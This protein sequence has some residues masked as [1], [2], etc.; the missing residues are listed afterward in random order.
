MQTWWNHHDNFIRHIMLASFLPQ[1]L[2][3]YSACA[4]ELYNGVF[5]VYAPEIDTRIELFMFYEVNGVVFNLLCHSII[6]QVIKTN[7]C[8]GFVITLWILSQ[9]N[10]RFSIFQFIVETDNLQIDQYRKYDKRFRQKK[11]NYNTEKLAGNITQSLDNYYRF[12][13]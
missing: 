11:L 9:N 12:V 4:V 10:L 7:I 5:V 1:N 2:I 6:T 3:V 8:L 13:T